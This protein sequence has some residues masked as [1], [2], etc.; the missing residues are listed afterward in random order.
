MKLKL[1][2]RNVAFC[3]MLGNNVFIEYNCF[4]FV[5]LVNNH[6]VFHLTTSNW[7]QSS[8]DYEKSQFANNE[9]IDS[10]FFT[11]SHIYLLLPR[12]M[13]MVKTCNLHV[14]FSE[15]NLTCVGQIRFDLRIYV[16]VGVEWL[17][18]ALGGVFSGGEAVL[19]IGGGCMVGVTWEQS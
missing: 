15:W 12:T 10:F 7:W 6:F 3:S 13:K 4:Y 2:K 11:L 19:R 1:L 9:S 14:P 8:W 5:W 16:F 17:L 18:S